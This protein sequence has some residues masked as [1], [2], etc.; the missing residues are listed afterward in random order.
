MSKFSFL[1]LGSKR[2]PKSGELPIMDLPREA[3]SGAGH[4]PILAPMPSIAGADAIA[5]RTSALRLRLHKH[6][7]ASSRD[8]AALSSIKASKVEY[9]DQVTQEV[10][11]RLAANPFF[12]VLQHLDDAQAQLK[13]AT[14]GGGWR[15]MP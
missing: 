4:A 5:A 14:A 9:C 3:M 2:E 12:E 1:G 8:Y 13:A 15:T 6:L 7:Q 11:R 10:T